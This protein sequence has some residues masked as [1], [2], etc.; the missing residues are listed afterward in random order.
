MAFGADGPGATPFGFVSQAA[1]NAWLSGL[2]LV[3]HG[4]AVDFAS[5]AGDVLTAWTGG[6]PSDPNAHAVFSLTLDKPTRPTR[7][8]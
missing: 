1:A 5:V 3:S 7:S 6:G 4:Q 8:T 2:G